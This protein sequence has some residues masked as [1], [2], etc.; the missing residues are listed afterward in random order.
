MERR[1]NID[2]RHQNHRSRP[3]VTAGKH[4]RMAA[5]RADRGKPGWILYTWSRL[6]LLWQYH[7]WSA[8]ICDRG[9]ISKHLRFRHIQFLRKHLHIVYWRVYSP[10]TSPALYRWYG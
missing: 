8:W 9:H 1:M 3:G 4:H 6:R 10:G 7:C 2:D 5:C